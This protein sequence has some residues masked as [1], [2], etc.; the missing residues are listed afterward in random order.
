MNRLFLGIFLFVTIMGCMSGKSDEK[1][2]P[3]NNLILVTESFQSQTINQFVR[4]SINFTEDEFNRR[5]LRQYLLRNFTPKLNNQSVVLGK[6]SDNNF[7]WISFEV[8]NQTTQSQ[9]LTFETDHIRCDGLEAYAVHEDSVEQLAEIKRQTPLSER[10]YPILTFSFPIKIKPKDTLTVLVRSERYSGINELNI[11]L[12][13]EKI[14]YENSSHKILNDI[15]QISFMLVAVFFMLSFGIVFKQKLLL[16]NGFFVF[17]IMLCTVNNYYFFDLVPVPKIITLDKF[18]V[19]SFTIFV[20]NALFHPFG[21]QL[22]KRLPFNQKRYRLWANILTI[23]NVL[24]IFGIVFIHD[25]IISLTPFLFTFLTTINIIWALYHALLAVLKAKVYSYIIVFSTTFLP[26]VIPSLLE[27]LHFQEN[28]YKLDFSIL[29][30]PIFIA[31]LGYLTINNFNKELISKD[32]SDE[33]LSLMRHNIEEIRK[34]EVENIGRNLHDSIGNNLATVLGYLNLK[35]VDS[36]KIKKLLIDSINEVRFLSHNLV[37][38]DE[39]PITEKIDSLVERF[40]DFSSINFQFTDFSEGKINQVQP[41]K[42]YSAYVIVQEA[43]NNIIK[44]SMASEAY[45]QIF[46]HQT[47]FCINI[48][49]NGIGINENSENN[50]IGLK[51]IYKRAELTN[52][53]ITIDST[54]NG[55]SLIIEISHENESYDY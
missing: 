20:A 45:V 2:I 10:V 34:S 40:N 11:R 22:F 53:K 27:I 50:G 1:L 35:N 7:G 14:F 52:L 28:G 41:V 54:P 15:F 9:I 47:C 30:T 39:R 23:L 37:R 36:Q 49:D 16:F 55:V 18:N 21:K 32:N 6:A 8:F 31:A 43:L 17:G 25:K 24:A 48:E 26:V 4:Y 51:N 13:K 33:N 5:N 46:N 12:S 3:K 38:D 29:N 19:G 44:H 42:Q